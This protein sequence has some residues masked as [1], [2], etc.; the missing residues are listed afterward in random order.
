MTPVEQ[1]PG[2]RPVKPTDLIL[3]TIDTYLAAVVT[4]TLPEGDIQQREQVFAREIMSNPQIG[5][6]DL[7]NFIKE[8]ILSGEPIV[9][10]MQHVSPH[11]SP[12]AGRRP[13]SLL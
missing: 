3:N 6:K 11:Q 2:Q 4:C 9:D 8:A 1:R 12:Q 13:N 5:K 10:P 7:V